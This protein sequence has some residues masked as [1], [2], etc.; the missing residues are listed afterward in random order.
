MIRFGLVVVGVGSLIAL[1]AC[2][3]SSGG[4]RST[5]AAATHAAPSVAP[6]SSAVPSGPTVAQFASV[7]ARDQSRIDQAAAQLQQ[8]HGVYDFN[9]SSPLIVCSIG[10]MSEA[11]TIDTLRVDLSGEG[12]P[13]AEIASLV[14]DT[15]AAAKLMKQ[16]EDLQ[17]KYCVTTRDAGLCQQA[18]DTWVSAEQEVRSELAAWKPYE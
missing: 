2:S 13:P 3:G 17:T 15:T 14:S 10:W 8:C 12:Q 18:T 9:N 5:T 6:P 1:S 11:L 4:A 7:V 16:A